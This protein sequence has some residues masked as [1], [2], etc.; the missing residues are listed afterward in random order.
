MKFKLYTLL[1][2]PVALASCHKEVKV[3]LKEGTPSFDVSLAA[4]N[5]YKVGTDVVF[6]FS[7]KADV[8]SFFS[9]ELY[10]DYAFK[11]GRT[12]DVTN[13]TMTF[14][15][16]VTGGTQTNQL[17]ILASTDFNGV[18]NDTLKPPLTNIHAAT[19]TDIT[20][21]FALGTTAT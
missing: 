2:V 3:A 18:Y 8:I 14:T 6:N 15:S 13:P 11:D 16:A 5:T 19:W 21:R 1:L 12:I 17:A 7:G 4:S 9:G 20:S 10:H